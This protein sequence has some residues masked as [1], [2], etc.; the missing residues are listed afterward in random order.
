MKKS[1]K[2]NWQELLLKM[3]PGE[4]KEDCPNGKDYNRAKVAANSLKRNG[5]GSWKSTSQGVEAEF[6]TM[7]REV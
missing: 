3:Q 2:I 4:S 1:E 6:F 5:Q 7:T